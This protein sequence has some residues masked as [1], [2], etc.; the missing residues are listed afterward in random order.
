MPDLCGM[1]PHEQRRIIAAALFSINSSGALCSAY[2]QQL[3]ERYIQGDLTIQ[4]A[5]ALLQDYN[6]QHLA[7]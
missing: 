2:E 4:Q 6:N 5:M 7:A 1:N 3:A